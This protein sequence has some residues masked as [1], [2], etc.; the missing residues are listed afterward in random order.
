M[1]ARGVTLDDRLRPRLCLAQ[2]PDGPD[3]RIIIEAVRPTVRGICASCYD[4][5]RG[6]QIAE[7]KARSCS[8]MVAYLSE[9]N[10]DRRMA[11]ELQHAVDELRHR[12]HS[13]DE[14]SERD[15]T[16]D[17]EV[18]ASGSLEHADQLGS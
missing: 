3:H 6:S 2:S 11:A 4:D 12:A 17:D 8:L 5:W 9:V 18:E 13:A 16:G 15:E 1:A 7:R 10:R 14:R